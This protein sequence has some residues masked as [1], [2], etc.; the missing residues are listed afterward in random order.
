MVVPEAHWNWNRFAPV[1]RKG[2]SQSFPSSMLWPVI[3]AR[4]KLRQEDSCEFWLIWVSKRS[5]S[6][7]GK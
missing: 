5:F 4:G 2:S 7:E 6:G 1:D 3:I